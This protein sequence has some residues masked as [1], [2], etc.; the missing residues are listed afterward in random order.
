MLGMSGLQDMGRG[1][2]RQDS[3]EHLAIEQPRPGLGVETSRQ[4]AA[5]GLIYW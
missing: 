1:S 5:K 3:I 2:D 4:F